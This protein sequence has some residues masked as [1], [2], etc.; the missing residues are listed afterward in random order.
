V[1]GLP[2][3]AYQDA[4]ARALRGADF[5]LDSPLAALTA[6]PGFAIYRNTVIK[7]CID[8]LQANYPAVARLVGDEWFRAAAA[9]FARESL[10]AHPT[11]L[12]YGRGFADFLQAFPPA[13][14]LPY[15]A[16]VAR[17]DRCWTEAHVAA[18]AP[19][20]DPAALAALA[21]AEMAKA[22][23]VPHP[24]A[25]WRWFGEAPIYTI[26]SCNRTGSGELGDIDWRG[27]G[28]LLTRPFGEVEHTS[29]SQAGAAFLDACAR[30]GSIEEVALAAVDADAGADLAALIRQ[31]LAAG[32]FT[33][34][35]PI[36]R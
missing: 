23:L 32:T 8:A 30:R 7:A 22:R 35:E 29:L 2:L 15:L 24:A 20:L 31:L 25:R 26:W 5:E 9:V 1:T 14:G 34:L 18:D 6:Q 21:P 12:D 16:D 3:A 11:L 36:D 28:A 17:L 33:S 13:S 19:M 27:E 10:P 4:F